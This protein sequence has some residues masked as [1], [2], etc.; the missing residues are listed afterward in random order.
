MIG[1]SKGCYKKDKNNNHKK[2]D[3]SRILYLPSNRKDRECSS[4]AI[5]E[6]ERGL[7]EDEKVSN[8][9][10]EPQPV[11]NLFS[12]KMTA[13]QLIWASRNLSRLGNQR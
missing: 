13:I 4:E 5:A 2:T 3:N 11:R 9:V 8:K 6:V 10:V 12:E 1:F 7:K